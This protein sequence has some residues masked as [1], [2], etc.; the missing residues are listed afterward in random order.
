MTCKR[1]RGANLQAIIV[2]CIR[3]VISLFLSLSTN[4]ATIL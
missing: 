2:F 1:N 3:I 4:I